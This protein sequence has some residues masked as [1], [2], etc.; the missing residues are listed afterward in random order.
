MLDYANVQAIGAA[1][2]NMLL[3]A[4]ELG[5]GSLWIGDILTEDELL[6]QRYFSEGELI[7]GIVLGFSVK[8]NLHVQRHSLSELIVFDGGLK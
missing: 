3:R 8:G 5:V 7:A 1:I 6:T 2:E 4:T